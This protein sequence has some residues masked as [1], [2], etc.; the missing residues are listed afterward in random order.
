LLH[1]LLPY[2][3]YGIVYFSFLFADRITAGAAIPT[4]SGLVFGINSDYKKGMDLALLDFLVVASVIEYLNYKYINFWRQ[5]AKQINSQELTLFSLSLKKKYIASLCS[6]LLLYSAL[7]L[8]L[9]Q[10]IALSPL[11]MKSAI[12]GGVGYMLFSIAILNAMILFSL[13][14]PATILK[15]LAFGLA[16]NLLVGYTLSHIV[17]IEYAAI[18]LIVGAALFAVRST[19]SVVKAIAQPDYAY[20]TA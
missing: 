13:S 2:F 6:I 4:A 11:M 7:W 5:M 8:V 10:C 20:F 17:S 9:K 16:A 3:F 1:L 19:Q 12:L 15:S 14:H 18:G